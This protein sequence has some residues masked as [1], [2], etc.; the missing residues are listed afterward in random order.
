MMGK[1]LK[2]DKLG[3]CVLWIFVGLT[4][5]GAAEPPT[6]WLLSDVVSL[7][8][9]I[10]ASS[11]LELR[12]PEYVA[13]A[14]GKDEYVYHLADRVFIRCIKDRY[15]LPIARLCGDFAVIRVEVMDVS[16]KTL[17]PVMAWYLVY[18]EERW[19]RLQ[20]DESGQFYRGN[21]SV[22]LMP[23]YATRCLD[24]TLK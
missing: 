17:I 12:H 19:Q 13:I 20:R 6:R 24:I 7:L 16:M 5:L 23:P 9:P 21:S 14:T 22:V 10:A 15:E 11:P 3:R 2:I 1:A 4:S 8:D 18:R